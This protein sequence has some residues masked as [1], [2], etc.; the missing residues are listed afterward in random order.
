MA[1]AAGSAGAERACAGASL[2]GE[3]LGA[4]AA[5]VALDEATPV[6]FAVTLPH[7]GVL[8]RVVAAAAAHGVTAVGP[9]R[10]AE[11][12]RAHV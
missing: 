5:R 1:R 10:G 11:I 2:A 3:D 4:L 9:R 12:G 7:L 6:E 8:V